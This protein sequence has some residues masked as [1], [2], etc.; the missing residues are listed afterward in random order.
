M[1]TKLPARDQTAKINDLLTFCYGILM[2][3]AVAIR[4]LMR[5]GTPKSIQEKL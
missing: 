1:K 4:S 5:A 2:S 3:K